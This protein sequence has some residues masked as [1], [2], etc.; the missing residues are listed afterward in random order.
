[1]PKPPPLALHQLVVAI[2]DQHPKPLEVVELYR[3]H[4]GRLMACVKA[5]RIG[6]SRRFIPQA[7]LRPMTDRNVT[8]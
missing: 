7:R 1:M 3:A 5:P 2:D 8:Q 6:A 4:D